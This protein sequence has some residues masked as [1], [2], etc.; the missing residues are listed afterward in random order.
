MLKTAQL[1]L[2]AFLVLV[3]PAAA[4]SR[5]VSLVSGSASATNTAATFNAASADG[6]RVFFT[7]TESIVGSAGG[8]GD[9]VADIYRNEGATTTLITPNT[10]SVAT[11]DGISADGSRV[12]FHTTEQFGADADSA[13]D[14]YQA[15]AGSYTLLTG[16]AANTA[17][18]F[19]GAS[20][21]GTKVFFE[22]AEGISDGRRRRRRLPGR[23]RGD[24]LA[25][26]E[27]EPPKLATTVHPPTEA[28]SSFIRSTSSATG[29]PTPRPTCT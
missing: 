7:T 3:A 25:H 28:G 14:I 16:G 18:V 21:D 17:A 23:G 9:G 4:Q 6:S 2:A 13:A 8:D 26:R 11:F 15:V 22:T 12:F 5:S 24:H 29:T 20:A 19:K 27:R 10:A 1:T